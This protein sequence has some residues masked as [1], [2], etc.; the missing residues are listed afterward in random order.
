MMD[1]TVTIITDTMFNIKKCFADNPPRDII[2]SNWQY[3]LLKKISSGLHNAEVLWYYNSKF[4][5]VGKTFFH[6]SLLEY[7]SAE[8]Y[9]KPIR[10]TGRLLD[11]LL[12][13]DENVRAIILEIPYSID[14]NCVVHCRD[15]LKD[16]EAY[17]S[18]QIQTIGSHATVI[19]FAPRKAE[20]V[21]GLDVD[22]SFDL[23]AFREIALPLFT[24]STPADELIHLLNPKINHIEA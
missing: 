23:L 15:A 9:H 16:I 19:V 5:K 4:G 8:K 18:T 1:D 10:F 17:L 22:S 2:W 14:M 7:F 12:S 11:D 21:L 24:D 6:L 13:R 3:K 20:R